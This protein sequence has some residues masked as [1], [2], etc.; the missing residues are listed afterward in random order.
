[1]SA[2]CKIH[3]DCPWPAPTIRRRCRRRCRARGATSARIAEAARQRAGGEAPVYGSHGSADSGR[4]RG[5][6]EQPTRDNPA[7]GDHAETYRRAFTAADSR[8]VVA[9]IAL[10]YNRAE[11]SSQS[12]RPSAGRKARRQGQHG[13]PQ[14]VFEAH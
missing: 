12:R 14:I 9:V 7:G 5:R 4:R 2:G 10:V 8:R 1:M 3:L 6:L 13:N 11:R